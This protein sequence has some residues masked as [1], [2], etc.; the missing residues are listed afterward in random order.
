MR[1][2]LL[3]VTLLTS[4]IPCWSRRRTPIC[5]GIWPFFAALVIISSTYQP[6][7]RIKHGR[8]PTTPESN[9]GMTRETTHIGGGSLEPG[10]G[11][12]LVR[13]R[14]RR[15]TLPASRSST[16]AMS[17]RAKF[18]KLE[19]DATTSEGRGSAMAP[20]A[21]GGRGAL[22]AAVHTPHGGG[23]GFVSG[24]GGVGSCCSSCGGGGGARAR[25]DASGVRGGLGLGFGGATYSE[26]RR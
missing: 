4:G 6:T 24:D 18:V 1:R 3:P 16:S 8:K 14:R 23:W 7:N 12:P 11:S 15:D 21:E 20:R 2:I 19:R 5:D 25:G 13:Q 22:P 9:R 26:W 10:R 17:A